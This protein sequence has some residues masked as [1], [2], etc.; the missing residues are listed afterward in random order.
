MNNPINIFVDCHIFD[1]NY[2]GTTTYIK[3]IYQ[4]YIHDKNKHF[5]LAASNIENLK[6][7]FG[8][9]PNVTYLQLKSKNKFVRL[10]FEIPK[11]LK[12]NK[13]DYAHFQY[14][15][16]PIKKCKYIVTI[17]DVLFLEYPQYFPYLYKIKN[18]F[19]FYWSA[20]HADIVC[21]VSEFSKQKIKHYFNVNS[22]IT[23]NAVDPV[24]YEKYDKKIVQEQVKNQ[25]KIENYWIFVSRWE[26][27]KNHLNLVKV[28]VENEYYKEYNLLFIGDK[29]IP[30]KL[31]DD[32]FDCLPA[33]VQSKIIIKN[34][35]NFHDLLLLLRGATLSVYPSFAE[36]FGIPPLESIAAQIPTVC[37]NTTAMADF[38]FLA[39]ATFDPKNLSEMNQIIH[40]TLNTEFDISLVEKV[41][42]KYN[43]GASAN[44]L[45]NEMLKKNK[46]V[47]F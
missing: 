44:V 21:T 38:D 36:G 39:G 32:Y 10:L 13:I 26:P 33:E 6:K 29:D 45:K 42:Q 41:K 30:N 2:Q 27:R 3:G 16:P 19:L 5:F 9:Q 25:F 7:V 12:V 24:F 8:N 15:A 23:P 4:E 14:I 18:K 43:W 35:V 11:I 20:K 47:I 40:I 22:I 46:N 37:S 17:H 1:K 34:K 31:Y 28:F